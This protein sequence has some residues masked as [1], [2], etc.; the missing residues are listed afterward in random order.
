MSIQQNKC[1]VDSF[2][3]SVKD[4]NL[5]DT[6]VESGKLQLNK[7][8]LIGF[9]IKIYV[10]VKLILKLLK[11]I[12]KDCETSDHINIIIKMWCM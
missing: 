8:Y 9:G 4:L 12:L 11:L 2:G 10:E 1:E 3:V 7:T 5:L 6:V